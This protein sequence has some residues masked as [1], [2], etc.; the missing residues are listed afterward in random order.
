MTSQVKFALALM[1][2]A[3]ALAPLVNAATSVKITVVDKHG[4]GIEDVEVKLIN[5]TG[6]SIDT[7][8]TDSDGETTWS[9]SDDDYDII[10]THSS[11]QDFNRSFDS[12]DYEDIWVVLRPEIETLTLNVVSPLGVD[13]EDAQVKITSADEKI[14]GDAITEVFGDT[15]DKIL[16]PTLNYYKAYSVPPSDDDGKTDEDGEVKF[17]VERDVIYNVTASKSGYTTS[18]YEVEFDDDALDDGVELKLI[19]PGQATFRA[20]VKDQETGDVI[21][22]A[23]VT[24]VS[25][26]NGAEQE[27]ETNSQGI[28]SFILA[29]P[30]C[31][32]VAVSKD[33]YAGDSQNN[34]CFEKDASSNTPFYLVSQN[35]AP[36]AN[37]GADKYVMVGDTVTLDASASSDPNGNVLTYAWADN[38]GTAITS[39]VNPVVIFTT[40]GEHVI[41]LNVSDGKAS[42]TDQVKIVVE[43]PQNCGDNICSLSENATDTCPLDCPICLDSVAGA[44]ENDPNSSL[45]CPI[46]WNIPAKISMINESQI[47]IGNATEISVVDPMTGVPLI[48]AVAVSYTH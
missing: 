26:G 10:A 19:E 45:Y 37:A 32:D 12:S 33:N 44:G 11:Y 43:S 20:T 29:T 1:L 8:S 47:V 42:S 24:I 35:E 38:L 41:T 4:N 21:S 3:I 7:K 46:D 14:D 6:S 15:Y 13:V 17:E 40:A 39:I 22:G 34:L 23:T 9:L 18:S 36:V 31:Y 27:E 2:V 28:A 48:G 16:F 30:D 5:S 25:K